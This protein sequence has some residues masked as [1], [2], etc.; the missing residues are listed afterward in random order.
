MPLRKVP[1]KTPHTTNV[2][3]LL[4]GRTIK[5]SHSDLKN[6]NALLKPAHNPDIQKFLLNNSPSKLNDSSVF[7]KIVIPSNVIPDPSLTKQLQE[8]PY[9]QLLNSPI[10]LNKLSRRSLP[11]DLMVPL[12]FEQR[13][14]PDRNNNE[15]KD[16]ESINEKDNQ[17]SSLSS[18]RSFGPIYIYPKIGTSETLVQKAGTTGY[19]AFHHSSIK[20][21]SAFRKGFGDYILSSSVKAS[22]NLFSSYTNS[23][24]AQKQDHN[25]ET[26]SPLNIPS[27]LATDIPNL[28]MD[29]I[30]YSLNTHILPHHI[31]RKNLKI[32]EQTYYYRIKWTSD[33]PSQN[34]PYCIHVLDIPT[35]LS[36]QHSDQLFNEISS[37]LGETFQSKRFLDI[38]SK[39]GMNFQKLLIKHYLFNL[40]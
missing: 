13:T 18:F 17:P 39:T 38:P 31:I 21:I 30:L 28:L 15:I 10:R 40:N 1:K 33:E 8:N 32:P 11:R 14:T 27:S 29:E 6:S 35:I 4:S 19:V 25:G 5:Q 37:K 23:K 36:P 3:A 2:L 7:R 34:D 9:A 12:G 26:V 22:S 16:T 24:Q 20:K